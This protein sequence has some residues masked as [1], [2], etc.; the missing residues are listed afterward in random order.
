MTS[1]KPENDPNNVKVVTTLSERGM[2]A[3]QISKVTGLKAP[4]VRKIRADYFD[5][6]MDQEARAKRIKNRTGRGANK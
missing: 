4:V 3:E 2:D 6:K 1:D 5:K